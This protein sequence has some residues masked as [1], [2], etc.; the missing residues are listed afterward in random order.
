[1]TNKIF[2][3]LLFALP[4]VLF[5]FNA[6]SRLEFECGSNHFNSRDT[7]I[8]EIPTDRRGKP[9]LMYR[10]IKQRKSQ[11]KLDS[12]EAGYDSLQIRVWSEQSR[13]YIK[14]LII[15]SK[16]DRKWRCLF[17]TMKVDWNDKN[18]SETVL[19]HSVREIIP[20]MGWSK[21]T[22]R[23]LTL[24]ITKLPN[25]P[26]GGMDGEDYCVEIATRDEYRFYKY[27][28]PETTESKFWGS[29]NMVEIMRLLEKECSF[30]E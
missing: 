23:L 19:T 25:G 8:R 28:S 4:F 1:M 20:S 13:A 2:G 18:D 30:S 10:V 17:Y 22:D 24:G 14:H 7:V 9:D 3:V 11:L 27:W 16:K 6:A 29:K 5:G 12:I 21:F 26:A 15:I